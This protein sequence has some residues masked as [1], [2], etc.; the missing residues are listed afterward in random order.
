MLKSNKSNKSVVLRLS[1]SWMKVLSILLPFINIEIWSFKDHF[2]ESHIDSRTQCVIM[3]LAG[4]R[5][6]EGMGEGAIINDVL[7]FKKV[8]EFKNPCIVIS[9]S[10]GRATCRFSKAKHHNDALKFR[11]TIEFQSSSVV[12]NCEW[13][14]CLNDDLTKI[15]LKIYCF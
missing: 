11:R 9:F 13:S 5:I 1:N 10:Y 15:R 3:T 4:P 14:N 12:M 8:I 2:A 6:G 7:K